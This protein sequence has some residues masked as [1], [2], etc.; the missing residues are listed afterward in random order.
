[1]VF[2]ELTLIIKFTQGKLQDQIMSLAEVSILHKPFQ[3]P[4]EAILP[5]FYVTII[6]L[7]AKLDKNYRPTSLMKMGAIILNKILGNKYRYMYTY[8]YS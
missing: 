7:I 3:G 1:M 4:E 5:Y 2:K 8:I 6:I